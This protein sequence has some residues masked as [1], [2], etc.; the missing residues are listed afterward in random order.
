MELTVVPIGEVES[1]W[2]E[3]AAKCASQALS[4]RTVTAAVL[5]FPAGSRDEKRGQYLG[6]ALLEALLP[7]TRG[8]ESRVLGLTEGDIFIPMLTFLFGQAQLG[9]RLALVSLA[10]LRPE[11]YNLPPDRALTGHRLR[12][13][14]LHE[15]GH[16]F[17]L[18][19]CEDRSCVMSLSNS[20][21]RVDQ[22]DDA[23]CPACRVQTGLAEDRDEV[24]GES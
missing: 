14:V 22:K 6:T 17:G 11:F 13:E 10:R 9:G 1:V 3:V 7:V 4:M 5:P 19:H 20:V 16:T 2:T 15:L 12:K 23:Y 21:V 18:V 8:P 24:Q